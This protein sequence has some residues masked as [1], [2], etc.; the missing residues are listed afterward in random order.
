[1]QNAVL[2]FENNFLSKKNGI[3]QTSAL[4]QTGYY[5]SNMSLE[6]SKIWKKLDLKLVNYLVI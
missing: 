3:M 6:L 5:G 1:M 2:N 4:P